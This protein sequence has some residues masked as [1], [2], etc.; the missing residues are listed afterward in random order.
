MG[1]LNAR[2]AALVTNEANGGREGFGV[3]VRPDAEV[4]R[5]DAS[6]GRDRSGLG[7]DQCGASHG[8]AAQVY[9]VPLVRQT[10]LARVFA[11]R[12]YADSVLQ[13]DAAQLQWFK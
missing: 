5:T 3:R 4:L 12:R 6:L 8:S 1:K 10:L 2:H 11:H 9:E 13:G 7:H